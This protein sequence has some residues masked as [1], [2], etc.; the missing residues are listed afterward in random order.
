[1][2]EY[3]PIFKKADLDLLD[4][5]DCVDGYLS[6]LRGDDE[7]GSDKSKSFWHGWRNG[8]VDTKRMKPDWAMDMLL[9]EGIAQRHFH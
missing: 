5:D 4:M 1:M 2:S 6:G 3:V 7:P 8:M 9:R